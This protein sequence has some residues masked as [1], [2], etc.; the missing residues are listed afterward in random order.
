MGV[1][2]ANSPRLRRQSGCSQVAAYLDQRCRCAAP[3]EFF[4]D[5]IGGQTL[6]NAPRIEPDATAH[7]HHA[8]SVIDHDVA[9]ARRS[10]RLPPNRCRS[11]RVSTEDG[12]VP[13]IDDRVVDRRIVEAA[14][15]PPC[16]HGGRNQSAGIGR[17][18]HRLP[19]GLVEAGDFAIGDEPTPPSFEFCHPLDRV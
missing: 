5:D 18:D 14:G 11:V 15:E 3:D 1:L 12:V 9:A 10:L 2:D 7:P 6:A 19:F 16:S 13:R 8:Q 17:D 4:G